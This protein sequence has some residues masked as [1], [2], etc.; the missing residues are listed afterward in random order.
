VLTVSSRTETGIR[1]QPETGTLTLN[2]ANPRLQAQK[3][4]RLTTSRPVAGR[5]RRA[6]CW[7]VPRCA[8][9]T[10]EPDG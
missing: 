2:D 3:E 9:T 8:G 7:L 1:R 5:T 10:E 4:W 6:A